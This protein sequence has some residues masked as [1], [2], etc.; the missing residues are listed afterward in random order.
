MIDDLKKRILYE[1]ILQEL[2]FCDLSEAMIES[3]G[4]IEVL[5]TT[6]LSMIAV[7]QRFC[8][9]PETMIDIFLVIA[10]PQKN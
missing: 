10:A 4:V 8:D 5:E 7:P 6:F 3:D 1:L 2:P 9:H